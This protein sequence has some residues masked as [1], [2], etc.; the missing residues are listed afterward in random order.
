MNSRGG[1]AGGAGAFAT[2][3]WSLI[4]QAVDEEGEGSQSA[5][6]S[7]CRAY[8]YP[9]Y[10]YARRSGR[11]PHDAQD[12]TQ[13]FF[14]YLLEKKLLAKADP[15]AGRF[16]SFLLGSFRHFTS[17]EDQRAFALKRGGSVV[18]IS[19]DAAQAEEQFADEPST[20]ETPETI[21]ERTWAVAVLDRAL[22]LL[23]HEYAEG[24]KAALFDAL[25]VFLTGDRGPAYAEMAARLGLTEAHIKV[26][27]HRL[28][29]RYRELLRSTVAHTV[30]SP[31]DVDTELHHLFAALSG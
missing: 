6:E 19:W 15:G 13:S 31:L 24:G 18:T 17:N 1:P 4:L 2:T 7:L 20:S 22:E 25:N 5:L 16:R 10:A 26:T 3:H 9:L 11:S 30:A 29:Q 12:L 28:R 14:N 21:Y 8:W 27:V 23:R